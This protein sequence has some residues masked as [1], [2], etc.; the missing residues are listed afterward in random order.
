MFL[1]TNELAIIKK[2]SR[3]SGAI[4]SVS[5]P[6]QSPVNYPPNSQ[7]VSGSE[8]I[9]SWTF[10]TAPSVVVIVEDLHEFTSKIS[11]LDG[12]VAVIAEEGE[13]SERHIT[14]FIEIDSEEL[15]EQIIDVQA[16]IIETYPQTQYSFHIRVVPR[17]DNGDPA[18]P[19]SGHY[20]LRSWQS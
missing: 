15:S 14:T 3:R 17:D 10:Y 2:R 18:L 16:D 9:Q 6:L 11:Q 20:F 1:S 8:D 4:S 13:S 12:V 7:W 19:S 5:M